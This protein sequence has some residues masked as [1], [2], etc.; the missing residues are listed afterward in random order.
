MRRWLRK[1]L[2]NKQVEPD[3]T[4]DRRVRVREESPPESFLLIVELMI[5]FFIGLVV[6]EVVH[7]LML[8]SWNDAVFGGIMLIVGTIVGAVFGRKENNGK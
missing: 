7:I 6:L 5:V 4:S 3:S 8:G 2:T 1:A